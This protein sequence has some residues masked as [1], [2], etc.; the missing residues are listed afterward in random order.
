MASISSPSCIYV[1]ENIPSSFEKTE[2]IAKNKELPAFERIGSVYARAVEIVKPGTLGAQPQ[3]FSRLLPLLGGVSGQGK[4]EELALQIFQNLAALRAEK[5]D[6]QYMGVYFI[7]SS[8]EKNDFVFKVGAKRAC[9][10]TLVAKH[11]HW[12]GLGDHT[13]SGLYCVLQNSPS[14]VLSRKDSAI[15]LSDDEFSQGG[16]SDEAP[17]IKEESSSKKEPLLIEELCNGF[18]KEYL[19][20]PEFSVG[21]IEPYLEESGDVDPLL[22]YA[23]MIML[24]LAIGL[25]DGKSD[26]LKK[27][28]LFDVEDCY[29]VR[30]DPVYERGDEMNQIAATDLAFL[31]NPFARTLLNQKQ[32]KEL[33]SIVEPWDV[34]DLVSTHIANESVLYPDRIA[35]KTVE[36]AKG[37]D[38]TGCEF[39]SVRGFAHKINQYLRIELDKTILNSSQK[40]ATMTRMNRL[41][42]FILAKASQGKTFTPMDTVYAVDPFFHKYIQAFEGKSVRQSPCVVAGRSPAMEMMKDRNLTPQ[43]REAVRRTFSQEMNSPYKSSALESPS[44]MDFENYLKRSHIDIMPTGLIRGRSASTGSQGNTMSIGSISSNLVKTPESGKLSLPVKPIAK[45][46]STAKSSAKH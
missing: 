15:G 14:E 22:S 1:S 31:E 3:E 8:L 5:A 9:M 30:I 32:I 20:L 16:F 42:D 46:V 19:A 29:P 23:K 43:D 17:S 18:E 39:V 33:V 11:A 12:M 7:G 25:R 27:H 21:I 28:T 10:E 6:E 4:T 2:A 34:F 26:G 38:E 41:R 35:E 40:I 37:I 36:N 45:P 13:V 24:S 44:L